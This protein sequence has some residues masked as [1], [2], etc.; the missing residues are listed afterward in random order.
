[1]LTFVSM[2]TGRECRGVAGRRAPA[3]GV[4][5]ATATRENANGRSERLLQQND[6]RVFPSVSNKP[7]A[8]SVGDC[9]REAVKP[10]SLSLSG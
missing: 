8:L 9:E 6:S 4:L 5:E 7:Q 2:T 3:E 1:M 10:N